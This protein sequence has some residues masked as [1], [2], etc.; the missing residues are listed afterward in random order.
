MFDFDTPVSRAGTNAEKYTALKRLFGRDDVLPFW[1]ADMEFAASSSAIGLL[2]MLGVF[3][4]GLIHVP[5]GYLADRISKKLI[6]TAGGLLISYAIFSFE[7]A[8]RI[9]DLVV[10]T[11]LFGLGGGISM[12]ALM[13]MVVLKGN[14]IN[15]M[16]S[17]RRKIWQRGFYDRAIRKEDDLVTIARYIVANPLRAGIVKS[18]G[19]YSLW[20]AIWM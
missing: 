4:S 12:P 13:A 11:V 8:V 2:V 17:S 9:E 20:D 19:Q 1:V 15:A 18:A 16:G 7:W 3:I 5:M 14:R 10:A 6:V